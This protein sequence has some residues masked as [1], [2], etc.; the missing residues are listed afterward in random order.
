MFEKCEDRK[1]ISVEWEDRK[2]IAGTNL[3]IARIA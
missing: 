3:K 2:S 1:P